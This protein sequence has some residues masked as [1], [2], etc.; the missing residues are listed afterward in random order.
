MS[1]GISNVSFSF[2]GNDPVREAI[3]TVFL[4]HAIQA[5]SAGIKVNA[6][7]LG[8]EAIP[9]ELRER[10]EDAEVSTSCPTP[11]SG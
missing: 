9:A 10:V 7:Q 6:G 1:G 4:Y 5:G 8:S 11:A 3:H 2:R